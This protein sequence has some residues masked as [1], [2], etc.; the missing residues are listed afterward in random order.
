[1]LEEFIFLLYY[2][3]WQHVE[4]TADIPYFVEGNI[5]NYSFQI[6]HLKRYRD[7]EL[8]LDVGYNIVGSCKINTDTLKVNTGLVK[9]I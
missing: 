3:F 5:L 4:F 2:S 6:K 9:K 7:K 1:M 8:K